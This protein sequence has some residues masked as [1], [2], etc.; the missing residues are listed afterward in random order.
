M[1][2]DGKPLFAKAMAESLDEVKKAEGLKGETVTAEP[3]GFEQIAIWI[4]RYATILIL[5]GIAGAYMEMQTPGFGLPGFVSLIAFGMF[6]FGHYVAGSLVGYETAALVVLF[7]LGILLI[8]V[9]FFVLPG[10]LVPGI[11]GFLCVMVA[12]VFTMSGWETPVDLPTPSPAEDGEVAPADGARWTFDLSTYALGLRNFALG[13]SGAGILVLLLAR[14]LPEIGPF[15]RMTL[16]TTVGGSI[17]ETPVMLSVRSVN[18][19]DEGVTRSAL[20]P[21]GTV[22]IAGRQVEAFVEGGYLQAGTTV[23]VREVSG[24]KITV[25]AV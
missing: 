19:G 3:Q 16:A 8:I 12:L 24:I 23:R 15:K 9:E 14:F 6:F 13:V 22:D 1:L 17:E 2:V 4:T 7:A 11:A 5:I 18:V 25:E 10:T 20:R 21:Y